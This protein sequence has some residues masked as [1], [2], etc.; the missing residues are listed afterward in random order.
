MHVRKTIERRN[1]S[2]LVA[3]LYLQSHTQSEHNAAPLLDA[4]INIDMLRWSEN[5][6]FGQTD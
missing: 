1:I 2:W 6:A 4:T 3:M 5:A